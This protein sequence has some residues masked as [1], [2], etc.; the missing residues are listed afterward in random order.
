M[1][2]EPRHGE[3]GGCGEVW[4]L[5]RVA[6]AVILPIMAVMVGVMVL[7]AAGFALLAVHPLLSLIPVGILLGGLFGFAYWDTR[8]R[9]RDHPDA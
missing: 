7:I 1:H 4:L 6:F 2:R 8:R 9:D 3:P 5:T